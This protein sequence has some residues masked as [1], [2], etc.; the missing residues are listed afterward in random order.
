[1]YKSTNAATCTARVTHSR[2][3]NP[4]QA[5]TQ[6]KKDQT[7]QP[8]SLGT[9]TP[10]PVRIADGSPRIAFGRSRGESGA[11]RAPLTAATPPQASCGYFP[12]WLG[13]DLQHVGL[14]RGMSHIRVDMPGSRLARKA[15]HGVDGLP[16]SATRVR[17][18]CAGSVLWQWPPSGLEKSAPYMIFF[19]PLRV[20]RRVR[21][22]AGPSAAN[23]RDCHDGDLDDPV[24]VWLGATRSVDHDEPV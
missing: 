18:C 2:R 15:L 4:A 17:N 23:A 11:G 6:L 1:M 20:F 10:R 19:G 8:S 9:P 7:R 12:G 13:G 21:R 14:Q 3:I 22:K 16:A 24:H 5:R